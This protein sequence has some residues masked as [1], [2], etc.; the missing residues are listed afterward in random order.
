MITILLLLPQTFI[1]PAPHRLKAAQ[2]LWPHF[3]SVPAASS[4]SLAFPKPAWPLHALCLCFFPTP[5]AD[6][7]KGPRC[8]TGVGFSREWGILN[9]AI[10]HEIH[11]PP[12]YYVLGADTWKD[13]WTY[14]PAAWFPWPLTHCGVPAYSQLRPHLA[15][16]LLNTHPWLSG[17]WFTCPVNGSC[18]HSPWE[19]S[20][21]CSG[22]KI[23]LAQLRPWASPQGIALDMLGANCVHQWFTNRQELKFFSPRGERSL[24]LISFF[25][26][27]AIALTHLFLLP[28]GLIIF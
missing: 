12:T 13:I 1:P 6:T 24:C 2:V 9:A 28:P 22:R 21:R 11:F 17:L 7:L 23:S 19:H 20:C 8:K 26:G 4:P 14:Q 10:Q 25:H 3:K 5:R 27:W 16:S 15:L 18:S